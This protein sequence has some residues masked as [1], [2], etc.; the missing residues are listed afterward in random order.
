MRFVKFKVELRIITKVSCLRV[1]FTYYN[2]PVTHNKFSIQCNRP[3]NEIEKKE[4]KK[5]QQ[6]QHQQQHRTRNLKPTNVE[7]KT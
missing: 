6:Q 3:E 2:K 4:A 5:K 1:Y 7:K